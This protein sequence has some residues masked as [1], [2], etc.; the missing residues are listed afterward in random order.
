[1]CIRDRTSTV[2]LEMS[3][4]SGRHSEMLYAIG[5]V[6][7]IFIVLLNLAIMRL[8]KKAGDH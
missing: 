3:Y 7:F 1:M 6:L 2:A 4:A 5:I 8:N